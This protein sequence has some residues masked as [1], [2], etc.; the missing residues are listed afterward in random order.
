M[1]ELSEYM[2]KFEKIKIIIDR[3]QK[4]NCP[5]CGQSL[6]EEKPHFLIAQEKTKY[7]CKGC[8]FI[9]HENQF[10]ETYFEEIVRVVEE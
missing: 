6:N 1:E 2:L 8:L 5:K 3:L 10:Y 4:S 9:F 7:K